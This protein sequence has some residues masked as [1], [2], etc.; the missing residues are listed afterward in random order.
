[1]GN[2]VNIRITTRNMLNILVVA[3]FVYLTK[4]APFIFLQTKRAFTG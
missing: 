1:V 3:L 2:A 4:I